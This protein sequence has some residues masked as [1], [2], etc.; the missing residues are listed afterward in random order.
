MNICHDC[1]VS[2]GQIHQW[3]C[4]MEACPFCGGQLISCD[5]DK[6]NEEIEAKGRIP[7]I[8][9]PWVCARCGKLWPDLFM[10]PNAEWKHYIE[11]RER[12]KILCRIC[13][14]EIKRLID[15]KGYEIN[16][17]RPSARMR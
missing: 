3:G 9:W 15:T 6:T 11:P 7:Y 16:V 17:S 8:Q 2:E 1:G 13:Y 10:V 4:D 12:D 14:E 5:C